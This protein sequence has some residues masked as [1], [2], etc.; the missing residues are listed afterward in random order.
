[1][2]IHSAAAVIDMQQ[3]RD[4]CIAGIVAAVLRGREN[5]TYSIKSPVA[6][7]LL[8]SVT[9]FPSATPVKVSASTDMEALAAEVRAAT[10]LVMVRQ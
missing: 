10:V 5:V 2:R 4:T 1:M 9:A 7:S 3:V 8:K 6:A